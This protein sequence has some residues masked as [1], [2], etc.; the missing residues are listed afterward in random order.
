MLNLELIVAL[1]AIVTPTVAGI[2]AVARYAISKSKCLEIIAQRVTSM[3][4]EMKRDRDTHKDLYEKMQE[5]DNT[6]HMILG[7]LEAM[8][9]HYQ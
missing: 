6:V 3:E 4:Y 2:A 7:K 9:K 8:E 5:V 1:V